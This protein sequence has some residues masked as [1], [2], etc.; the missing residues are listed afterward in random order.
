MLTGKTRLFVLAAVLF[1]PGM[2]IVG[3]GAGG[4][5][6]GGGAA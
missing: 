3:C 5:G 6:G 4:G 2:L 1:W